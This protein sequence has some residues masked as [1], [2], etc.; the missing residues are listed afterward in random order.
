[1][2]NRQKLIVLAALSLFTVPAS[3]DLSVY[4]V[5]GNQQFGTVDL[6]T[7]AYSQIGPGT[8]EG[9]SVWCQVRTDPC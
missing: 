9:D 1:M 4:L 3:A 7:G 5:S 2:L 8:P 6:N